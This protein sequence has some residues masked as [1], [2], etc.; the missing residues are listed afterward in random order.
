MSSAIPSVRRVVLLSF[1]P[2]HEI[3]RST[4]LSNERRPIMI[5]NDTGTRFPASIIGKHWKHIE[6]PLVRRNLNIISHSPNPETAL[7]APVKSAPIIKLASAGRL[8]VDNC[9]IQGTCNGKRKSDLTRF[10]WASSF[11]SSWSCAPVKNEPTQN[12]L[13]KRGAK[14]ASTSEA[15]AVARKAAYDCR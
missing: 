3:R 8:Q 14:N 11:R 6:N 15:D 4:H 1:L 2:C 12:R 13:L 5:S 7:R 10:R 9:N